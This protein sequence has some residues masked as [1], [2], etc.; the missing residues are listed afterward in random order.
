MSEN[1]SLGA[2]RFI[3]V[4][5]AGHALAQPQRGLEGLGEPLGQIGTH[6]EAID[7]G[8]DGVLAAYIE[9]GCLIEFHH[10]AI[11]ARPHE[12]ARLQLFDEFGVLPLA[13]AMAGASSIRAVPSGC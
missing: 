7:D 2:L 6:L 12:A 8:F 10:A 4:G 5:D 1:T 9:F 11:D 3:H 13:L